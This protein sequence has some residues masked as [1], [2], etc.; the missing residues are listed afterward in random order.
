MVNKVIPAIA[1]L[2]KIRKTLGKN[3]NIKSSIINPSFN[4][5]KLNLETLLHKT[6]NFSYQYRNI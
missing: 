6:S 4:K 5:E 2:L 3:L 1:T